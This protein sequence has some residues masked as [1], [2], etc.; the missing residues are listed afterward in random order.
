MFST[1]HSSQGV[2]R[3]QNQHQ[4]SQQFLFD[5]TQSR[6][7]RQYPSQEYLGLCLSHSAGRLRLLCYF[8][9]SQAALQYQIK[10]AIMDP[11][12]QIQHERSRPIARHVSI[13]H[14]LRNR[15]HNLLSPLDA[16]YRHRQYRPCHP[17]LDH[18][19][20]IL[21]VCWDRVNSVGLPF[22]VCLIALQVNIQVCY[23][24]DRGKTCCTM[25]TI[26]S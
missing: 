17:V 23:P 26:T 3:H 21:L 11:R 6:R 15:Q 16:Y 19:T 2:A 1:W 25:S 8:R 18:S 20:Q 9:D 4:Y 14:N 22:S 7:G 5:H 12:G 10:L 13:T 24:L